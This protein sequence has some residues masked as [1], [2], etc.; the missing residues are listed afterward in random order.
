MLGSAAVQRYRFSPRREIVPSSNYFALFIA[1]AAVNHLPNRHCVDLACD[2][3]VHEFRRIF[4]ADAILEKRLNINQ[5][6][7]VPNGLYSCSWCVS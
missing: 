6:R 7:R 2:H 1:P 4:A 5:R 3:A